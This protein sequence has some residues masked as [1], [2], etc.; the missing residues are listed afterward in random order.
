MSA[1]I[2]LENVC[3]DFGS[4]RAVDNAN[5]AIKPGEFFSFLGPSGSGK[6]TTLPRISG[7]TDPTHGPARIGRTAMTGARPTQPPT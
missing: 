6:T 5:V 4:F 3:C 7:F 1:G 2:E